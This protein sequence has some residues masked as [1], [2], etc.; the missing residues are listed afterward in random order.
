[1]VLKVTH[2]FD[3]DVSFISG[4]HANIFLSKFIMVPWNE[5]HWFQSKLQTPFHYR[6]K[7]TWRSDEYKSSDACFEI[8]LE[9]PTTAISFAST[10]D[11]GMSKNPKF[12][13][14]KNTQGSRKENRHKR[15][16]VL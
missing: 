11:V 8:Q 9:C 10:K 5:I 6:G 14:E 1:M 4:V 3:A 15:E 2:R 7:P 16:N 13:T 12:V